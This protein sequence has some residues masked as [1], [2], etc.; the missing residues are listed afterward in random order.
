MPEPRFILRDA[1]KQ[2]LASSRHG[3]VWRLDGRERMGEF[4]DGRVFDNDRTLLGSLI[5]NDVRSVSGELLGMLARR[6]KAEDVLFGVDIIDETDLV[7]QVF[8]DEMMAA[9]SLVLFRNELI[10][11]A[12]E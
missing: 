6:D 1:N 2:H 7:G 10:A 8:G 11:S 9:A 5:G 3:V 4:Y 12:E